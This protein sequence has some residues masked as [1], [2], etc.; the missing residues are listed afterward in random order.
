MRRILLATASIIGLGV[1]PALAEPAVAPPNAPAA[2]AALGVHSRNSQ[3]GPY[4]E[5]YQFSRSG[6]ATGDTD[7][8]GIDYGTTAAIPGIAIGAAVGGPVGAAVGGAVGYTLGSAGVFRPEY[9]VYAERHPLPPVRYEARV[10]GAP[11]PH[12]VRVERIPDSSYD[13]FY[14][15]SSP[16]IISRGTREVV[17]TD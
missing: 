16:V 6:V 2:P 5:N 1:I 11:V 4:Y 10:A 3:Y 14:T 8:L 7:D 12:Y 9:R 15:R 17:W 13:Y